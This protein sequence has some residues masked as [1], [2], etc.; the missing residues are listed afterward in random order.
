LSNRPDLPTV[1]RYF[2]TAS[3]YW[4]D[5]YGD[6]GLQGLIYRER[7]QTALR[8][9][10]DLNLIAGCCALDVGC[11]AGLMAVQLAGRGI[12]V[13]A[14]D[15]SGAMVTLAR[16]ESERARVADRMRVVHADAHTLPFSCETFELVVAL[17]LLPWVPDPQRIVTEMARV[18]KPG[19]WLIL[20]A[21]NRQRL[22]AVVEPRENPLFW[23][24][25]V[26][27]RAY[28]RTRP[29][30]P[31]GGA[32]S[33][34]HF[35]RDVQRMLAGAGLTTARQATVGFGPFTFLGR[36]VMSEPGARR[37]HSRL[38]QWSA[39]GLE[40]LR[41]HGWHYVVAARKPDR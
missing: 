12:R 36:P 28:R 9:I 33:R 4:R 14:T 38:R 1:E 2:D 21:D 24:L 34:L 10:D 25:K 37:L 23:P 27:L 29:P 3:D 7:M 35:P 18:L 40:P 5:V 6:E 16:R 8:W 31:G 26:G 20:T 41:R 30:A 19:G 39:S 13:T 32:P 11:G 22:N 17:G 15:S